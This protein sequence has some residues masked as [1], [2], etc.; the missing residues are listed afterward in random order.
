[1]LDREPGLT[2]RELASRL[3][4]T[5]PRLCQVLNLL[6]LPPTVRH[7]VAALSTR[8]GR[9]RVT[10]YGL[11]RIAALKSADQFRIFRQMRNGKSA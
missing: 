7:G 9:E 1:M 3:G 10:E 5:P 11:R 4:M 8:S 2:L 6:K